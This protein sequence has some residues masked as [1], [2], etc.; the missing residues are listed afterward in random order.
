MRFQSLRIH[1]GWLQL[2]VATANSKDTSTLAAHSLLGLILLLGKITTRLMLRLMLSHIFLYIFAAI[3]AD[4]CSLQVRRA[5]PDAPSS[6]AAPSY[7]TAPCSSA[8][9]R[10]TDAPRSSPFCAQRSSSGP[11]NVAR[12][13]PTNAPSS[14]RPRA[15]RG[16][17]SY[18]T[19]GANAGPGRDANVG[20]LAGGSSST[21]PM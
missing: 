14:G 10:S 11:R 3:L 16:F 20:P 7:S 9:P 8:A 18:L 6:S 19:A 4:I 13:A 21:C 2:L 15:T 1:L 12:N 17:M 5:M